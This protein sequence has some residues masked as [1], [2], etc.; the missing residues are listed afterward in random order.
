M[1]RNV[2]ELF[3][4]PIFPD[5]S[6]GATGDPASEVSPIVTMTLSRS[7]TVLDTDRA[8]IV[9]SLLSSLSMEALTAAFSSWEAAVEKSTPQLFALI[10]KWIESQ[11]SSISDLELWLAQLRR[12]KKVTYQILEDWIQLEDPGLK[13]SR[14]IP[15]MESMI[16]KMDGVVADPYEDDFC[17]YYRVERLLELGVEVVD[18]MHQFLDKL[19]KA[20]AAVQPVDPSPKIRTGYSYMKEEIRTWYSLKKAVAEQEKANVCTLVF[21]KGKPGKKPQLFSRMGDCWARAD[22]RHGKGHWKLCLDEDD[23]RDVICRRNRDY[24]P[25]AAL[26]VNIFEPADEKG[27]PLTRRPK[28]LKKRKKGKQN[29]QIRAN[30]CFRTSRS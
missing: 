7:T 1:W 25:Q 5:I 14:T 24:M 12:S 21:T 11:R 17:E 30:N 3:T 19:E 27:E 18:T 6:W 10:F 29:G 2:K 16:G 22:F 15:S 13:A 23:R 9:Q 20:W 28:Q 26:L 4:V 8:R